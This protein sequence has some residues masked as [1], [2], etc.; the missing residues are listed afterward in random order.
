MS[1]LVNRPATTLIAE[2]SLAYPSV[3]AILLLC[4]FCGNCST[5]NSRPV[6]RRTI[7]PGAAGAKALKILHQPR[8]V[9]IRGGPESH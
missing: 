7:N 4:L 6:W 2:G 5:P 8:R 3:L 1:I 9:C